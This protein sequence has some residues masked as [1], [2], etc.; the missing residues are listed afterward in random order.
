MGTTGIRGSQSVWPRS[1]QLRRSRVGKQASSSSYMDICMP[2]TKH[3]IH[4]DHQFCWLTL[5]LE[6]WGVERASWRCLGMSCQEGSHS[7]RCSFQVSWCS[8]QDRDENVL[9]TW[10]LFSLLSHFQQR[11]ENILKSTNMNLLT[12]MFLKV[13]IVTTAS[14]QCF[15]RWFSAVFWLVFSEANLHYRVALFHLHLTVDSSNLL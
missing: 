6:R 4:H 15:S 10:K 3:Q 13:S 7:Y 11:G 14:F 5:S 1:L 9:C 12:N 8:S 2:R